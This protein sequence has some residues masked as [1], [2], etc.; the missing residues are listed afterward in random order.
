M[1][2]PLQGLRGAS[3]LRT[4]WERQQQAAQLAASAGR[5]P[6][7]A[8]SKP[9]FLAAQLQPVMAALR[10]AAQEQQEKREASRQGE[11]TAQGGAGVQEL[12]QQQEEQEQGQRYG[13]SAAQQLKTAVAQLRRL[14]GVDCQAGANAALLLWLLLGMVAGEGELEGGRR[15]CMPFC[16]GHACFA[17]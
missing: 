5:I 16:D 4:A 2:P 8:R 1:A 11:E 14:V 15:V 12:E 6:H 13:T 10:Q 7:Q 9:A 17:V 3:G